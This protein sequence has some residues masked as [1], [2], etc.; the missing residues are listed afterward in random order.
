LDEHGIPASELSDGDLERELRHLYETRADT[1]FGGTQHALDAHTRRMLELEQEYARR[2]PDR[3]RP[4][5]RRT[6]AGSRARAGQDV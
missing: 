6:R 3:V 4:D 1:F 2:F 5:E